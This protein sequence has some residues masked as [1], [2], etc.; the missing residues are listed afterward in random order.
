MQQIFGVMASYRNYELS[1]R[2][3]GKV[4][5]FIGLI[6]ISVNQL[7]KYTPPT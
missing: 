1:T 6:Y 3:S 5:R 2:I 7:D 4:G